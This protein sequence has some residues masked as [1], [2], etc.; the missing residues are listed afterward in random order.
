MKKLWRAKLRAFFIHLLFSAVIIGIFMIMVTQFWFPGALFKL[1]N[2]WEGLR[3][4]VP[5][6]AILGP[7]LTLI[8]FAPGKKGLKMDLGIIGAV[9]IAALI[10]GGWAIYGAKPEV[11][12]WVG[13]RFEVVTSARFDRANFP[14]Q[15]FSPAQLGYP[16]MVYAMPAQTDEERNEFIINNIQ[17]QF[18]SE[19]YRPLANYRESLA[20]KALNI[21]YLYPENNSDQELL[22]ELKSNFN[23]DTEAVF[24]LQG[25]TNDAIMVV[26]NLDTM[27]I[28]KYLELEPWKIYKPKPTI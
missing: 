19:R 14:E 5:V 26:I 16:Q 24:I 18:L 4:L 10:Y 27:K 11:I 20:S 13:D 23:P 22:D 3:I 15:E 8:I 6:D 25:T 1:E 2:V 12:A 7:L 17:Y 9:Q 21:D 28:S